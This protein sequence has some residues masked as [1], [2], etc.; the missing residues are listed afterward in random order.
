M[1]KYFIAE[2]IIQTT[3]KFEVAAENQQD[4]QT[5][6]QEIAMNSA[7]SGQVVK[8][9]LIPDGETEYAVGLTVKHFLFGQGKISSLIRTTNSMDEEGY[10]ATIDFESGGQKN[11]HLPMPK[12]KLDIVAA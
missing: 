6:A 10:R 8:L 5:N 7:Q 9:T 2:A 3:I 4:A 1:T 11:I 12:G